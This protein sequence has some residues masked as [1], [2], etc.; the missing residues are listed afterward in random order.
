MTV[1][2]DIAGGWSLTAAR[3]ELSDRTTE[4]MYEFYSEKPTK[5]R[6]RIFR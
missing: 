2:G 3:F 6:H 5:C 1:P 4:D